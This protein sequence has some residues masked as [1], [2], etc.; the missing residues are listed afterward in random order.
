MSSERD[1]FICHASEDKDMIVRPLVQAMEQT[2]ISYWYDEGEIQWGDSITEKVNKGLAVAKYV[3]A[4]LSDSFIQKKWPQ[5][6]LNAALNI[7]AS[8][9]EVRVLPLLVGSEDQKKAILEAYPILNDKAY[10]SWEAGPE[11]VVAALKRRLTSGG[12][13]SAPERKTANGM[14]ATVAIPHLKKAFTQRD[15]DRFLREAFES[16]RSYFEK[17]AKELQAAYPHIDMDI[18]SIDNSKFICSI[19]AQGEIVT[20]CMIWVGGLTGTN[21]IAY[22]SDTHMDVRNDAS[23][24]D[25][26]SVDDTHGWLGL[27]SCMSGYRAPEIMTPDKAAEYLWLRAIESLRHI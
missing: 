22:R 27:I 3:L 8:T 10:M 16:I 9:G 11:T 2:A 26:L 6:E 12:S 24:T 20:K 21:G 5:R 23:L 14:H 19:Y 18:E 17:G 7:E 13:I 25:Q 15:K 1:L 4:V